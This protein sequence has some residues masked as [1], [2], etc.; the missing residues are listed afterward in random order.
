MGHVRQQGQVFTPLGAPRMA[1]VLQGTGGE[2]R[3]PAWAPCSPV[4]PAAEAVSCL[5]TTLKKKRKMRKKWVKLIV[6]VC[7]TQPN[8]PV[9][10]D[11]KACYGIPPFFP[12]RASASS[13][14][15]GGRRPGDRVLLWHGA[16]PVRGHWGSDGPWPHACGG[17]RDV[18]RGQQ[19]LRFSRCPLGWPLSPSSSLPQRAP[20]QHPGPAPDGR[21]GGRTGGRLRPRSAPPPS[22]PRT[23]P[24][25][26]SFPRLRPPPES[27]VRVSCCYS[28]AGMSPQG[29][30]P[31]I[32][33]CGGPKARQ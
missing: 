4:G 32:S 2:D 20:L 30:A 16:A 7:F 29:R 19:G 26:L 27:R 1:S 24:C 28:L 22:R 18:A 10:L 15:R 5:V 23:L 12:R 33:Q 31:P 3:V 25:I 6:T 8:I 13:A 11:Y 9:R 21:M 17:G 14:A